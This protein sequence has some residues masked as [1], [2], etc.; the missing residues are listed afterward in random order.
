MQESVIHRLV[1]D[2]S[3]NNRSVNVG[4]LMYG[5]RVLLVSVGTGGDKELHKRYV[6]ASVLVSCGI[7]LVCGALSTGI[8][9]TVE[10][11]GTAEPESDWAAAYVDGVNGVLYTFDNITKCPDKGIVDFVLANPDKVGSTV[12]TL[13]N[14]TECPDQD[15]I[16]FVLANEAGRGP[17]WDR[18]AD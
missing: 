16:D 3:V 15:F 2:R 7:Y 9:G 18:E 13:E 17:L 12:Y 8:Q 14:Y 10:P 11:E 6:A 4:G 5:H 1:I